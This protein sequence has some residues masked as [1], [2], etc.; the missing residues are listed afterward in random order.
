MKK[1]LAVAG[2]AALVSSLPAVGV[3]AGTPEHSLTGNFSLVSEYRYRCI[4]QTDKKPALQGG[5]DYAHASG[6]YLGV[7]GS[8]ASWIADTGA[9]SNSL[10]LDIYGGYKR[11][12]GDFGIDVGV[13]QYYFPGTYDLWQ[14]AGNPKPNTTELY[15]GGNWKMFTLK[16]SQAVSD[17][18]G[19]AD[20]KGSNYIDLGATFDIGGGFTLGA[21]VGHQKI[22][23]SATADCSYD[24]WKLGINKEFVGL[25]WGLT[26]VGTNA[27]GGC[28][29]NYRGI[30]LGKD[31]FVLSVAK[32]F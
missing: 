15:L 8:N 19:F 3:A 23:T 9:A 25:N 30:N 6:V 20:S 5:F 11:S 18:F 14:A 32:T 7:W 26:Y 27:D 1:L 21:H 31:T 28:Y 12:F 22:K 16:Y 2:V 4:A 29:T 17:I 13:L 24:D 10:E